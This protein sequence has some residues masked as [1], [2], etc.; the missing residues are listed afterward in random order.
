MQVNT[1]FRSAFSA[2]ASL[3]FPLVEDSISMNISMYIA[4]DIPTNSS[5]NISMSI[6]ISLEDPF[7]LSCFPLLTGQA[8]F[9]RV[10]AASKWDILP[11]WWAPGVQV[12]S[13]GSRF[14]DVA[15]PDRWV[16]LHFM[17]ANMI[18]HG[19]SSRETCHSTFFMEIWL[20]VMCNST[21]RASER[22]TGSR[23][24]KH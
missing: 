3:S 19:G 20:R 11:C 16:V 4:M 24:G 2:A 21:L 5:M 12:D 18:N 6:S 1:S 23:E 14:A 15:E 9:S 13:D 17:I 8:S 22:S 7:G 10:P